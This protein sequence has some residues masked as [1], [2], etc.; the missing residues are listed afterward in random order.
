[1]SAN[2]MA[3]LQRLHGLGIE[4]HLDRSGRLRWRPRPGVAPQHVAE[5]ETIIAS[6]K[7]EIVAT[8]TAPCPFP[9]ACV[10]LGP[11]ARRLRGQS[12]LIAGDGGPS[13]GGK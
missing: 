12:C 13:K 2:G 9:I 6:Q 11:C 10:G 1:M 4:L 3:S 8:L 7:T 5:A